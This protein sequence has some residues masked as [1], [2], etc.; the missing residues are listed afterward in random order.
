MKNNV[1]ENDV[2]A[3]VWCTVFSTLLKQKWWVTKQKRGYLSS[4]RIGVQIMQV[5]Q[6]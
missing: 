1:S 6:L 5:D 3:I 4:E 2:I